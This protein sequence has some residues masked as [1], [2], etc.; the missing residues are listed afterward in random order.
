M[1]YC[2]VAFFLLFSNAVRKGFLSLQLVMFCKMAS[3]VLCFVCCIGGD[4]VEWVGL[5]QT[6]NNLW[7]IPATKAR[8]FLPVASSAP[9]HYGC[10]YIAA[11]VDSSILLLRLYDQ[12]LC[13]SVFVPNQNVAPIASQP[14][15]TLLVLLL[16]S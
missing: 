13:N 6:H 16:G 10:V 3:R 8:L 9:I 7:V 4:V 15:G 5:G 12:S 2:Y 11:S 14:C 1:H